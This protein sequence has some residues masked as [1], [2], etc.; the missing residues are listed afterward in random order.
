MGTKANPSPND[1]YERAEPDEELFTL[2]ARDPL[3]PNCVRY[4]AALLSRNWSLSDALHAQ[5]KDMA[6]RRPYRP[7]KDS[8]HITTAKATA[9]SMEQWFEERQRRRLAAE[10]AGRPV[11]QV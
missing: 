8:H 11:D 10:N 5:M 1:P 7:G 2:L 4:Y 3:A 6:R 9:D